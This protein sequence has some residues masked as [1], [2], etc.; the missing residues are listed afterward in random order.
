MH[1]PRKLVHV[2]NI[3]IRW[4]D[5]DAMGHVNNT[6]Y[7]RYMEQARISWFDAIGCRGR[8]DGKGPIIV[9]ANCT[10]VKQLKYPGTVEVK[11]FLEPAGRSSIQSLC[12]LRMAGEDQVYADGGAK[13]VWMDYRQG[14][15]CPLPEQIRALCPAP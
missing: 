1:K 6:V 11:T 4:G 5:M 12:E 9:T 13:I 3:P 7:F 2:E 15:S 14:K 10:F 8:D